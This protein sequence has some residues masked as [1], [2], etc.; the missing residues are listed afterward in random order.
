[1]SY[2]TAPDPRD[3]LESARLYASLCEEDPEIRELTEAA[4]EDWPD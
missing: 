1:M 3:R 4:I 2:D